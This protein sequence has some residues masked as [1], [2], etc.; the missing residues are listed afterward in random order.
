M[1]EISANE[2]PT[3]D[4]ISGKTN[5]NQSFIFRFASNEVAEI[6]FLDRNERIVSHL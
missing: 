2:R 3:G 6:I 1:F 5:P 4:N